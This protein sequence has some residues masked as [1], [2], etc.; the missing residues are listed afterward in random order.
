MNLAI[1]RKTFRDS[2]WLV[3]LLTTV[4]VVWEILFIRGVHDLLSN[5][6]LSQQI[7]QFEHVKR[8]MKLFLGGDLVDNLTPTGVLTIGFVHPF[9]LALNWTLLLTVC[10][11]VTTGEIERGTADLMLTLPI[12]RSGYYLSVSAVWVL[13]G[14]PMSLAP[15]AG[16][17][18]GVNLTPL[19]GPVDLGRLG[20][21]CWFLVA[22]YLAVG[23][24]AMLIGSILTTRGRAVGM[25]L[26][27]L[28]LSVLINFLEQFWEPIRH[29]A[30]L[31]ILHYYQPL[32]LV[33]TG[34]LPLPDLITLLG[35]GVVS[36]VI[37]WWR[38]TR[39]DIPAA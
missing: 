17:A 18:V 33:R 12:S 4:I 30:F 25:M 39:R 21:L 36:W 5:E 23:G 9:L 16:V 19:W 26:G 32:P 6:Q 15:L 7:L 34:M 2:L 1:L 29:I 13:F 14:I 35:V 22:M 10:T 3:A 37:G 38:F 28:L 31:G 20:M 27:L 8:F 11:R 24:L